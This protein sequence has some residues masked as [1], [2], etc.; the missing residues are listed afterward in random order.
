MVKVVSLVILAGLQIGSIDVYANAF[1]L[2]IQKSGITN[3]R[4]GGCACHCETDTASFRVWQQKDGPPDRFASKIISKTI[5]R[6]I[7]DMSSKTELLILLGRSAKGLWT[8]ETQVPDNEG[9]IYTDLVCTT[10]DGKHKVFPVVKSFGLS[11]MGQQVLRRKLYALVL[12]R[13]HQLAKSGRWDADLLIPVQLPLL[14]NP[15]SLVFREKGDPDS[16]G[17]VWSLYF[18]RKDRRLV[19]I[20]RGGGGYVSNFRAAKFFGGVTDDAKGVTW[21]I[22]V[23]TAAIDTCGASWYSIRLA[24]SAPVKQ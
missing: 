11:G 19:R 6:P 3:P 18:R 14:A 8:V 24:H 15:P 12:R 17:Y 21:W 20:A 1:P 2:L 5:D 4:S 16:E 13:L 7:T 22:M 10:S 23:K 9:T